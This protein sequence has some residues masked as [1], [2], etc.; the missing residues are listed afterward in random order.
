MRAGAGHGGSGCGEE[1]KNRNIAFSESKISLSLYS[2]F[3]PCLPDKAMAK[4]VRC[5]KKQQF[6]E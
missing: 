5:Q 3:E 6:Y 1:G 2:R 4:A